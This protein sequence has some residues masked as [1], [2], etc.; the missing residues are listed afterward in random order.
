[1]PIVNFAHQKETDGVEWIPVMNGVQDSVVLVGSNNIVILHIAF[2]LVENKNIFRLQHL[3]C[4]SSC[5]RIDCL[6]QH[7]HI[8]SRCICKV[9]LQYVF[10]C[11]VSMWLPERLKNHSVHIYWVFLQ[12]VFFCVLAMFLYRQ[13]INHTDHTCSV[14]RH[15]A[16]SYVFS[17]GLLV[18]LN[19]CT[20]HTC[21]ASLHC[22]FSYGFS[23]SLLE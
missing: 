13:K 17:D 18:S 9:F 12:C 2:Q 5:E 11:G 23:D 22:A 4:V 1:M 20:G 7:T 3:H 15:C 6:M 14:S 10:Y 16:F 8:H 19:S 21:W